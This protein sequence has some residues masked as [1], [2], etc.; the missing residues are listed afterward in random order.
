MALIPPIFLNTVVA[1]GMSSQNGKVNY[2]ATGFIV[3]YPTG[4]TGDNGVMTYLLFLVTNR[5]VFQKFL[6]SKAI[7]RARFNRPVG[8][9][10]NVYNID[11][12][13]AFSWA[14]H[15]D[16]NI[17]VAVCRINHAQLQADG[18]EYTFFQEDIHALTLDQLLDIDTSEGD[19]VFVL[20][21][22]LG[23]V[24]EDR[25]YTIVRQGIIA[26]VQDWLKGNSRTFLIDASIFPGNSGGPVL[27]KP[28]I[29]S[30]QGTK[31]TSK[32]SLIGMVSA[33]VPYS[34]VAISEQTGRR[35]MVFEENSG[36]GIVVPYDLIQETIR[37][38]ID[39]IKLTSSM[40]SV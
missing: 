32:C 13:D 6:E 15:P 17:D 25:N 2:S 39:Q 24:G 1:L 14:V 30:I 7:L 26:R 33:Y 3:G 37:I 4:I 31:A 22:P 20:G 10:S 5:H 40:S 9:G 35:R 38:V 36:L 11:V 19:G 34:E 16:E 29:T 23:L 27:L 8:T 28:E 12:T 18:I 21:F